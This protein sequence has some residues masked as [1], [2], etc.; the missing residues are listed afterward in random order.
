MPY[1]RISASQQPCE[2]GKTEITAFSKRGK[3]GALNARNVSECLTHQVRLSETLK[4]GKCRKEHIQEGFKWRKKKQKT[5]TKTHF[6]EGLKWKKKKNKPILLSKYIHFPSLLW[7]LPGLYSWRKNVGFYWS[8]SQP[9]LPLWQVRKTVI[10]FV[11]NSHWAE[12]PKE[13]AE[14]KCLK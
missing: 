9:T 8:Y 5:K 10:T 7:Y 4:E 14:E 6:K 12:L 13:L 11:N 2:V 1:C 3:G